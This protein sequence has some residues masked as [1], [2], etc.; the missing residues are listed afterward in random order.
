MEGR[1]AATTIDDV[2]HA[3][4]EA[5]ARAIRRNVVEMVEALGH[6]YV[7]QGLGTADLFA[8]LYFGFLRFDPANLDWPDR[9]RSNV[10]CPSRRARG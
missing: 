8:A 4:L 3:G 2:D 7:G 10:A 5:A 6:G 1:E 9:D